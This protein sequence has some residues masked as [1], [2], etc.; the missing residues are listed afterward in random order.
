ME[1]DARKIKE[2]NRQDN[3]N[4]ENHIKTVSDN[5]RAPEET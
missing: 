2:A 1:K 5:V 4:Y 3:S